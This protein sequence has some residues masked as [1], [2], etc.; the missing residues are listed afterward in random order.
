MNI[1]LFIDLKEEKQGTA[2]KEGLT[3]IL[4]NP[5]QI[6][7]V[8]QQFDALGYETCL[9]RMVDGS[10]HEVD[11]DYNEVT[12]QLAKCASYQAGIRRY[13]DKA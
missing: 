5:A 4:I 3:R 11:E 7:T 9:I 13:K 12:D 1:T 6:S 8:T 2:P 10:E